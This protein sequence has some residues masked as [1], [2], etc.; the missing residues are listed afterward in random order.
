MIE[1]REQ[2]GAPEH[3]STPPETGESYSSEHRDGG[4]PERRNFDRDR[5]PRRGGYDRGGGRDDRRPGRYRPAEGGGFERSEDDPRI[6]ALIQET[7]QKLM[8]SRQPAQLENLNAFERKQ[9][10]RHFE[11]KRPAFETKTYRGDGEAQVLWIIPVANLKKFIEAQARLAVD[12]D[13]EIA[14][15]PMSNYERFIAHNILKELD[16]IE[17]SS[18]GE[19]AERHVRIQPKKF[20]R[21]LKKIIKKIKL[22]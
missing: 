4:R 2:G 11:R 15:P 21:S 10:H 9:V 7:E 13:S 8:D 19:G 22:M 17:S 3:S 12:T 1:E 14:L 20:G 5:G 6:T 18:A 16:N